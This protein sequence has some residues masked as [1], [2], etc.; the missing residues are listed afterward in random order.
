MPLSPSDEHQH[1]DRYKYDPQY[2]DM[3]DA[4]HAAQSNFDDQ[5]WQNTDDGLTPEQPRQRIQYHEKR[6]HSLKTFLLAFV[7]VFV[8]VFLSCPAIMA[9]VGWFFRL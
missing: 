1:L 4:K 8:V 9:V 6:P 5:R 3:W 7:I 2:Q